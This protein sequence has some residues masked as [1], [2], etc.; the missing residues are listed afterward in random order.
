MTAKDTGA[1]VTSTV[2]VEVRV[3]GDVDEDAAAYLREK[4]DAVLGRPGVPDVSGTVRVVRAV[5]H[6][7]ERPWSAGAEFVVGNTF[8]VVHAQEATAHEL[9]DR[10]Q[11]RLRSRLHRALHRRQ[12]A[13]RS[14]TPPPWRG[15]R[16]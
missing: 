10:L 11:D 2:A 4:L 9:A 15:G 5:A 14:A 6:H 16:A 3:E 1:Q 12:E 8:V 13:R 7:A